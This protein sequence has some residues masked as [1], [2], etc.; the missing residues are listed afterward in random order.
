MD[1]T[2]VCRDPAMSAE[3]EKPFEVSQSTKLRSDSFPRMQVISKGIEIKEEA[4]FEAFETSEK[5]PRGGRNFS[6][7][8]GSKD[9]VRSAGEKRSRLSSFTSRQQEERA[10]KIRYG[11][12]NLVQRANS[13]RIWRKVQ[14]F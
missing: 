1:S 11:P 7:S 2:I 3:V 14:R 4:K 8:A 9:V 13:H 10:E 5:L 6:S 12:S